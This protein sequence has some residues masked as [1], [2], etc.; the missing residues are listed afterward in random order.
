LLHS[1]WQENYA[2]LQCGL[3]RR[4]L[5]VPVSGSRRRYAKP[6]AATLFNRSCEWRTTFAVP[7]PAGMPFMFV[8]VRSTG[9][10]FSTLSCCHIGKKWVASGF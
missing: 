10:N 1:F 6:P 5:S 3:A 9:S 7:A 2:N 4:G 8:I